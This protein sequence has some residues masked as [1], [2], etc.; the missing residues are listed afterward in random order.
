M[1]SAMAAVE[2]TKP[3][4]S[5]R[6]ASGSREVGTERATSSAPSA[7]TG[8]IA[9][10][11]LVQEKCW[12]SHPPTIGPSAPATL[13]EDVRNQREGGREDERRPQPHE[14]ARHDQPRGAR[15]QPAGGA[16]DAE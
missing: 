1:S 2:S 11:M 4:R 14:A 3:G 6:G 15:H 12:S 13:D 5:R 10:K 8:V 9:K 7:A 16:R